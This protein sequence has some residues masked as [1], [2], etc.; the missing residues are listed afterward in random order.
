[1][2]QHDCKYKR[3]NMTGFCTTYTTKI[4]EYNEDQKILGLCQT[5]R[6]VVARCHDSDGLGAPLYCSEFLRPPPRKSGGANCAAT[7]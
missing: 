4:K 7:S 1:M 2:C 3:V 5:K 6:L